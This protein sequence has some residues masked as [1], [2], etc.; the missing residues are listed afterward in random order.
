MINKNKY[1]Y[2]KQERFKMLMD[3][4]GYYKRNHKRMS[5]KQIVKTKKEL[6]KIVRMMERQLK[7]EGIAS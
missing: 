6:E 1:N 2:N 5:K 3:L 4:F 7:E